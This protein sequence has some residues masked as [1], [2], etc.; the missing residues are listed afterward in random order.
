MEFELWKSWNLERHDLKHF[1]KINNEK[2]LK[3]G[4][5]EIKHIKTQNIYLYILTNIKLN[6]SWIDRS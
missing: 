6:W 3:I 1:I 2:M 4:I 5:M